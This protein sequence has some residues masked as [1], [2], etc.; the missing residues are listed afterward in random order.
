MYKNV[1]EMSDEELCYCL[2]KAGAAECYIY[3]ESYNSARDSITNVFEEGTHKLYRP[4]QVAD[5]F[6]TLLD[7]YKPY[8]SYDNYCVIVEVISGHRINLYETKLNYATFKDYDNNV[9][10]ALCKAIVALHYGY[11][12]DLEGLC[13]E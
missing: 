7:K 3:G 2:A 9:K 4:T 6:C 10:K 1:D 5:Q 12:F 8:V 13:D 11:E